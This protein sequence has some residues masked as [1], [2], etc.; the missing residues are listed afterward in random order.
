MVDHRREG[1]AMAIPVARRE[2][3]RVAA[4]HG[5]PDAID[6]VQVNAPLGEDEV[7]QGLHVHL[8]LG[9]REA[10]ARVP[11]GGAQRGVA[12]RRIDLE[13]S[14]EEPITRRRLVHQLPGVEVQV[15][16]RGSKAVEADQHGSSDT[17]GRRRYMEGEQ[18]VVARRGDKEPVE[19]P[20]EPGRPGAGQAAG[21]RLPLQRNGHSLD[22]PHGGRAGPQ[23]DRRRGGA[24]RPLAQQRSQAGTWQGT[25]RRGLGQSS[26]GER[27][28]REQ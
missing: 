16:V 3:E 26:L 2:A 24:H 10:E 22:P 18:L 7:D 27:R 5:E 25:V 17:L 20:G 9:G 19:Q 21:A 28:R 11:E 15:E 12:R 1:A 23:L 14:E 6:A 13:R 4:A 8:A